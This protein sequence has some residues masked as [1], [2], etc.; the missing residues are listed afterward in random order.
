M[1]DGR[2]LG[3]SRPGSHFGAMRALLTA[4]VL[5]AIAGS[6]QAQAWPRDDFVAAAERDRLDRERWRAGMD[7][8][9]AEARA[10]QRRTDAVLYGLQTSRGP[11]FQIPPGPEADL[12]PLPGLA[13]QEAFAADQ[14][15]EAAVSA[16]RRLDQLDAWLDRTRP[17]R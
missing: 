3:G 8:R 12:S 1:S 7:Q 5:T 2:G 13:D 17:H 16:D 11:A 9:S 6:A 4:L 14:A 10:D 15:R